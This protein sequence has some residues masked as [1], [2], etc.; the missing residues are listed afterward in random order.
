MEYYVRDSPTK[1]IAVV[2]SLDAEAAELVQAALE[3]VNPDDEEAEQ[4]ARDLALAIW[5]VITPPPP[6]RF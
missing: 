6:G 4:S 2:I 3:I 1:G 5:S